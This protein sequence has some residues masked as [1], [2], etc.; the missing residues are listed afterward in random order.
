MHEVKSEMVMD[1]KVENLSRI[2]YGSQPPI[3]PT[4]VTLPYAYYPFSYV[5]SRNRSIFQLYNDMI[6][7]TNITVQSEVVQEDAPR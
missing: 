4:I 2:N 1:Q 7:N 5:D 6:F 3:N